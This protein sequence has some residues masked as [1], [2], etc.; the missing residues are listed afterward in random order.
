MG[1]GGCSIYYRG[2][3]L[4]LADRGGGPMSGY[5]VSPFLALPPHHVT[6]HPKN[7]LDSQP[8]KEILGYG[9]GWQEEDPPYLL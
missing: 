8:R 9:S 3:Y 1:M 6:T 5:Y 4:V 2:D 7:R